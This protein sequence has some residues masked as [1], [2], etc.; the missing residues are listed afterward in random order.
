MSDPVYRLLV[1]ARR[2]GSGIGLPRG[3]RA[4]ISVALPA[5]DPEAARARTQALLPRTGWAMMG[6]PARTSNLSE[7]L[8]ATGI[9]SDDTGFGDYARQW[10]ER[11]H[12]EAVELGASIH[13]LSEGQ[14]CLE[15]PRRLLLAAG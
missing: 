1:N 6:N 14:D 10:L 3:E 7:L 8:A 5:P 13:L 4:V 2:V 15:P 11:I 12:G 9:E